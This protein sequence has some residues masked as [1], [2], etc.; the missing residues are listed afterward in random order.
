[1]MHLLI[2]SQLAVALVLSM[3]L[4]MGVGPGVAYSA[5]VGSVIAIA[6]N[7]FLAGRLLRLRSGATPTESLRG[8]YAGEL[9]KIVFT[10]ALFVITIEILDV[11]FAIVA[12]AYAAMVAINWLAL[13]VLDL[14]E[15]PLAAEPLQG[16]MEDHRIHVNGTGFTC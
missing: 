3:V 4:A 9:L 5:L 7:F 13:L 2:A 8:I 10:T 14:S 1:M 16:P 12:A 15:A 6:P 11:K